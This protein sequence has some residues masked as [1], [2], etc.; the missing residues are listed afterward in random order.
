MKYYTSTARIVNDLQLY[1]TI[2]S[3]YCESHKHKLE[4]EEARHKKSTQ[5]MLTF[6]IGIN[7]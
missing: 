5:Y 6:I 1:A 3:Q 7:S 4:Q 2:F